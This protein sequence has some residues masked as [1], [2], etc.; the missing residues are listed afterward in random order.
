MY[1]KDP[2]SVN[3]FI[4]GSGVNLDVGTSNTWRC[5]SRTYGELGETRNEETPK[6][7]DQDGTSRI[8][9]D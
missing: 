9:G 5:R 7:K 6:D 2:C 8:H 1:E 3:D 4:D